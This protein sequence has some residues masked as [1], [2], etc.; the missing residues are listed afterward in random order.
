MAAF[1]SLR[2]PA[3]PARAAVLAILGLR[4]FL[5]AA[6]AAAESASPT[7]PSVAVEATADSGYAALEVRAFG[8]RGELKGLFDGAETS[9]NHR[10]LGRT[11][12]AEARLAPGDYL[13]RVEAPGYKARELRV[14][15]AERTL[16]KIV[17]TLERLTGFLYSRVIPADAELYV[18]GE[19]KGTGLVELPTG[20]RL[21]R[22]R[23]FAHRDAER[24]VDIAE[25]RTSYLE[26]TL[27]PAPFEVSPLRAGRA[28]FNPRNAG[29]HG[30]SSLG[31]EVSSYGSASL[32]IRDAGGRLVA[33][34]EFPSFDTWSQS[35]SW[36][37]RDG[38]GAP[39]PDGRYAVLLEA[40]PATPPGAG[41]DAS[42]A[43]EAVRRETLVI[44]DSRLVVEPLGLSF[45]LPGL[46]HFADPRGVPRGA[47]ALEM[48]ATI[49]PDR[50]EPPA[51]SVGAGLGVGP[52]FIC[53]GG[54]VEP[55]EGGGVEAALSLGLPLLPPHSK[56][57]LAV[58]LRG[59]FGSA[60]APL[61]PGAPTAGGGFVEASLPASYS[62]GAL[63]LG[64]A[65]GMALDIDSGGDTAAR[66]FLRAGLWCA[67]PSFQVGLSGEV[68]TGG[69]GAAL[70][71]PRW[72][73]G[74][75]A[76][77]RWLFDPSPL[78]AGF[79][80]SAELDPSGFAEPRLDLSLG[81][82]L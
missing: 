64:L 71:E 48:G 80:F 39:L 7:A 61:L 65:P 1:P 24:A 70:S 8:E 6:A 53:F 2:G 77:G 74:L 36:N 9:L 25:G 15:L 50:A 81:M 35:F 21:V 12:V 76:E 41:P 46:R 67:G 34:T 75:A 56:A 37:G 60:A 16:T 54:A 82:L 5:G 43:G 66:G 10:Y 20:T 26:A 30:R 31:F 23:R 3:R 29:L 73:A 17:F 63:R 40:R 55:G 27:E 62:L 79:R 58:F 69:Q 59:A 47:F 78:V 45:G 38:D 42:T 11:P 57:A 32:S 4:L 72:P 22:I 18:D 52:L 28:S 51:V 19:R 33:A 44:L 13:V 68:A 14:T 49:A